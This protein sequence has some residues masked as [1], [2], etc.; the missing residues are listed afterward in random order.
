MLSYMVKIHP[1]AGEREIASP[2]A[3]QV[4]DATRPQLQVNTVPSYKK[5]KKF[6]RQSF[7]KTNKQTKKKSTLCNAIKVQFKLVSAGRF[8]AK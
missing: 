1:S 4:K 5:K 2:P 7:I 3:N 8:S 6:H